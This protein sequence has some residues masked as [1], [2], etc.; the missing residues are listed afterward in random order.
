MDNIDVKITLLNKG[1]LL[2]RA[3][4]TINTSSLGEVKIK[5]FLVWKSKYLSDVLNDYYNVTPPLANDKYPVFIVENKSSWH[6]LMKRIFEEYQIYER[7]EE[8]QEEK[9]EQMQ[10]VEEE[11]NE[12]DRMPWQS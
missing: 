2:A 7:G 9:S 10:K 8:E 6:K 3:I 1:N 11:H 4:V 5:G 12:S